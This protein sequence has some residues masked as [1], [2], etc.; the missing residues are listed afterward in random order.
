[1]DHIHGASSPSPEGAHHHDGLSGHSF[2]PLALNGGV[3]PCTPRLETPVRLGGSAR[4]LLALDHRP[5]HRNHVTGITTSPLLAVRR[6]R[7]V[8]TLPAPVFS[9]FSKFFPVFP[10]FL[11]FPASSSA[12]AAGFLALLSSA[13]ANFVHRVDGV[14]LQPDEC[15]FFLS[16]FTLPSFFRCIFFFRLWLG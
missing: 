16:L 2:M 10:G 14:H 6:R 7:V 3:Q 1:M 5:W 13:A 4:C 11:R 9:G 12:L 8:I 15:S